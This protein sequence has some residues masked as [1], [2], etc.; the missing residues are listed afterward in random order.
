MF[1]IYFTKK[2]A[3]DCE[4]AVK[5]IVKKFKSR[6]DIL[7]KPCYIINTC[8]EVLMTKKAKKTVKIVIACLFVAVLIGFIVCEVWFIFVPH[9]YRP[10][11][12]YLIGKDNGYQGR[13][14]NLVIENDTE[15]ERFAV[16]YTYT[17]GHE[18]VSLE[19]SFEYQGHTNGYTEIKAK[20]GETA[21][22]CTDENGEKIIFD[23]GDTYTFIGN[24]TFYVSYA[25][26]SEEE[27]EAISNKAYRLVLN[28]S[29]VFFS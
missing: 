28:G 9:H 10:Q 5:K 24:K 3:A 2:S 7:R 29:Y 11:L 18:N 17:E 25:A 20:N 22:V 26:F 23:H 6:I 1:C 27:K 14:Y 15:N 13:N 8:E 4:K 16:E 19:F 12:A 21:L